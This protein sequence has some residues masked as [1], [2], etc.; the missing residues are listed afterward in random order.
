[1]KIAMICSSAEAVC[2]I[3]DFTKELS[4]ALEALGEEVYVTTKI[5]DMK[6]IFEIEPDVVLIQHEYSLY[7]YIE[8]QRLFIQL[9]KRG[10]KN[11]ITLHGWND[12]FTTMNKMIESQSGGIIVLNE[13][14][15]RRLVERGVALESKINAIPMGVRSFNVKKK[16]RE[17]SEAKDKIVG[18]FGFLELYKGFI[19][20]I[21]AVEYLTSKYDYKVTVILIAFTK[22]F[23]AE[24]LYEKQLDSVIAKSGLNVI[25]VGRGTFLPIDK[26]L[27]T[28]SVCD[29]LLYPYSTD[30]FTYSSS[31]ALRDGIASRSPVVAT[32]ITFFDDVPAI[33]DKKEEG[34]ILKAPTSSPEDLALAMK[35]IFEDKQVRER[36]LQNS[37]QFIKKYSW[38]NVAL[39]YKKLFK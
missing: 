3:G 33:D 5:G 18:M 7:S 6:H 14:F 19:E 31:A 30:M 35:R 25:R 22:R 11:Y 1:M 2:G 8:L 28:L 37:E 36:L 38:E 16:N 13:K 34:C 32:D 29:C 39:Q 4:L 21:N 10:I 23:P 15:K 27:S 24:V 12:A 26:V 9:R 20:G 17:D